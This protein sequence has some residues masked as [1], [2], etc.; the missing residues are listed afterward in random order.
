MTGADTPTFWIS[1][2]DL[3]EF[4]L[5]RG[6]LRTGAG[7]LPGRLLEGAEGHRAVQRSRPTSYQP[8]VSFSQSF[9]RPGV[10]LNL[11]GRADGVDLEAS[12]PFLEEIKTVSKP[13]TLIGP[14]DNP[15][16]W[17]QAEVYAALLA[18]REGL[19]NIE[20]RLTYYH[21]EQK[22]SRTFERRPDVSALLARFDETVAVYLDWVEKVAA[23]RRL[24]DLCLRE[25]PFPF[26]SFR[27][28][29]RRL[30][31]DVYRGTKRGARLFAEAPTGSGKTMATLFGAL[32]AMGDGEASQIVFMSAKGPGKQAA[33]DAL[34]TIQKS[35]PALKWLVLTARDAA[36]ESPG[37][38][39]DPGRCPRAAGHF[40]RI[41]GA[42]DALFAGFGNSKAMIA[43]VAAAH[44]VCPHALSKDLVAW[45]DVIVCDYNYAF[46]PLVSLAALTKRNGQARRVFLVDEAHNL[47]DRAREMFSARIHRSRFVSLAE[48]SPPL[49]G[50]I[51]RAARSVGRAISFTV[52]STSGNPR[53]VLGE[54]PG[55]LVRALERF[56]K[57]MELGAAAGV[58][59]SV[60]TDARDTYFESLLLLRAAAVAESGDIVIA[61]KD[62]GDKTVHL[63][64]RDPAGRLRAVIDE[65]RAAA[66]FF[67]ATLSPI[68]YFSRVLGGDEDD[69]LLVLE[70]PFDP[71][72]LAVT[73]AAHVS[74]RYRDR[75]SSAESLRDAVAAT[76]NARTG[77][78]LVFFPSYEYLEKVM[79]LVEERCKGASLLVQKPGMDEGEKALFLE[80]FQPSTGSTI[81]GAAVLG[82]LFSEGIDL[83]GRR[84][85][86]AIIVG[87]GLPPVGLENELIEEHFDRTTGDGFAFAYRYPGMNKV[88]QAAGRVIRSENDE[89]IIVLIDDRY[90]HSRYREL[91]PKS[92]SAPVV[93][94]STGALEAFAER[95]WSRRRS[96][97]S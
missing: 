75:D 84:L 52:T 46:D 49:P 53:P 42:R 60:R 10:R 11:I 72:K 25:L 87:V 76:V 35:A 57:A 66:T 55:R 19:E 91:L 83:V 37:S 77:N 86:G 78:Y 96:E 31:A 81:I 44:R 82:G 16:H 5:R 45:C 29:Q 71:D 85:D 9:E 61:K 21:I 38:D 51:V 70:S 32:R 39:C 94:R 22:Q 73:V 48:G 28:G 90:L 40:D 24:R 74:T 1:V 27:R 17:A 18:R 89:G 88:V 69:P 62:D 80:S 8:E 56:V 36:C 93:V 33:I 92:W 12:P 23:H 58:D 54:L 3:V 26:G 20:V 95:F 63:F 59:F 97:A 14:D 2:R 34:E 50:D 4:V 15:L 64:C 65:A 47:L 43:E 41:A 68:K 7:G 13:L 67:S 79:P 30:A 6:D